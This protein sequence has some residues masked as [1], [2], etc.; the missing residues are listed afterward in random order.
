MD[1]R[2]TLYTDWERWAFVMCQ[3]VDNV[4]RSKQMPWVCILYLGG[5]SK[6]IIPVGYIQ[7][8]LPSWLP[9]C[10]LFTAMVTCQQGSYCHIQW[11]GRNILIGQQSNSK[12][13]AADESKIWHIFITAPLPCLYISIVL[14]Q[15]GTAK[16]SN[17]TRK[18]SKAS[19]SSDDNFT[20]YDQVGAHLQ[21][22]SF[23][24]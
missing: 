2:A 23:T 10:Y 12:Q 9:H 24:S 5:V 7:L 4:G 1:Y 17:Q 21:A 18:K 11:T 13:R 3:Q 20:K 8:W 16:V 15:E 6:M 22:L 19:S 14:L